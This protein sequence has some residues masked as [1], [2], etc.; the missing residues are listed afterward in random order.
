MPSRAK[1]YIY[2]TSLLAIVL[3]AL[4]D[5]EWKSIDAPRYLTLLLLA[6]AASALEIHLPRMRSTISGGFIFVLIGISEFSLAQS[7]AIAA[8]TAFVPSV[9]K[10]AQALVRRQFLFDVAAA[11]NSAA[12]A[13]W[14]P[15][16]ILNEAHIHLLSPTLILAATV[17]FWTHTLFV[18]IAVALAEDK[19]L[20]ESWRQ[21]S[22]WSYC[23]FPIQI[24]LATAVA[25]FIRLQGSLFALALTVGV[26]SYYL[27]SKQIARWLMPAGSNNRRAKP[28]YGA[29]RSSV[30][31]T[32]TDDSGKNH[33]VTA[34]VLDVSELG[35]K[36]ESPEPISTPTV[37]I[38][39]PNHE[40][41]SFAR[42][43]HSE[44]REGKYIVGM[45][46]H[47]LLNRRRLKT[48]VPDD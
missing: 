40:V 11:M 22:L 24:G 14:L 13:Y 25:L 3:L 35:I 38:T 37:R 31:V 15:R 26:L 30:E 17:Y 41:D 43:C 9:W 19:P 27:V 42:V 21:F 48:F 20:H 36:L 18:L 16:S 5:W 32:W 2:G 4:A 28:R 44:L 7:M 8:A 46:L 39:A 29:K 45:E 34:R 10:S 6:V 1:D 23:Y 47:V 33:N 12:A